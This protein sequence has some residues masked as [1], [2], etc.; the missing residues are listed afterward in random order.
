MKELDSLIE[1]TF[2]SKRKKDTGFI[3]QDLLN[4]VSEVMGSPEIAI[5]E[6]AIPKG[7]IYDTSKTYDINLIPMPQFCERS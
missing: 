1:N 4:I 2:S 6:E 5:N 7:A 3:F